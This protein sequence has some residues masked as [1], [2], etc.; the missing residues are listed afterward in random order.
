MVN[1]EESRAAV[2]LYDD[3][4]RTMWI[5]KH[6]RYNASDR[7]KKKHL[8]SIY[9]ISVLSVYVILLSLLSKYGF[10]IENSQLYDL[11][12]VVSAIFILVLSLTEASKNYMVASEKLFIC[13]NETRDLLDELKKYSNKS[14]A[15]VPGIE[16]ISSKY[17]HVLKT[18]GENH[19]TIDFDLLRAQRPADFKGI[20]WF[21]SICFRSKYFLNI[22]RFYFSL[23]F[24]PPV[25][26]WAFA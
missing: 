20:N 15:D 8:L 1:T 24:L 18:C 13:G 23:L 16:S 3:L 14:D 19:E 17:S 10:K 26:F 12:S 4:D 7:L 21:S 11:L 2:V 9:T 6:S 22:Y 5:T 25:I